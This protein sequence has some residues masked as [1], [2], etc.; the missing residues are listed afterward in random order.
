MSEELCIFKK[1]AKNFTKQL[2]FYP[3]QTGSQFM[4]YAKTMHQQ[5]DLAVM[6]ASTTAGGGG[7]GGGGGLQEG[8]DPFKVENPSSMV[9]DGSSSSR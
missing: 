7:L 3:I 8:L 5:A 9:L 2:L 1:L 4:E 6:L